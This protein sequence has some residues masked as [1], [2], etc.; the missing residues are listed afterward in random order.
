MRDDGPSYT[1][2]GVAVARTRLRRPSTPTGDADADDRLTASLTDGLTDTDR[3]GG[4][5]VRFLAYITVRTRFFDDVVLDAIG[6][7]FSQ[8]VILGRAMTDARCDSAH[9]ACASSKWITRQL[10][11]TSAS[12]LPKLVRRPNTSRSSN[13]TSH[14]PASTGHCSVRDTI[15]RSHLCSSARECCGTSPSDGSARCYRLRLTRRHRR[16]AWRSASR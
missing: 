10:S 11:A 9:P 14:N 6:N 16:A 1:A 13:P 5:A 15:R 4:D 12:D 3:R 7:G 2:R 8:V